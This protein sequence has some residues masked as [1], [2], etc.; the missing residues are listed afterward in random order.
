MTLESIIEI[1]HQRGEAK[2]KRKAK[3]KAKKLGLPKKAQLTK[4]I[5][6][7][8][9]RLIIRKDKDGNKYVL[10]KGK[11][12]SVAEGK[13]IA[14]QLL[15][16]PFAPSAI[17]REALLPAPIAVDV[18]LRPEILE[19]KNKSLPAL[20]DEAR[21]LGIKGQFPNRAALEE[22]VLEKKYEFH[23]DVDVG[24]LEKKFLKEMEK[25]KPVE[26]KKEIKKDPDYIQRQLENLEAKKKMISEL[27]KKGL[28]SKEQ[29]EALKEKEFELKYP[30]L[31]REKEWYEKKKLAQER[32]EA[33][34]KLSEKKEKEWEDVWDV[35]REKP[36]EEKKTRDEE[37]EE[38]VNELA[39]KKEKRWEDIWGKYQEKSKGVYIDNKKNRSLGLVGLPYGSKPKEEKQSKEPGYTLD[40][41]VDLMRKESNQ[42][43][44]EKAYEELKKIQLD[45]EKEME[46]EDQKTYEVKGSGVSKDKG[47]TDTQIDTILKKYPEYLGTIAHNEIP[48]K[49]LP[50]ITPK[51]KGGF[52]IN[53][54]PAS[55]GGQHWQA[56]YFDATP[57]GTHEINFFDSY[58]DPI[59]KTLQKNL[60][61]IA[62]KL[63]A[64]T[65]LKFKENRIRLQGNSSN[66]GWF[67][68]QFL[69]DRFNGKPFADAS[70]Y[71]DSQQGEANISKFKSQHG[72]GYM[73]SGQG[74]ME[75]GLGPAL[76]T[77]YP[78]SV[79]KYIAEQG[80]TPIKSIQVCRTP[81]NSYVQKF[82]NLVTL[83]GLSRAKKDT[84]ISDIFHLYMVI[85]G[86][87]TLERNHVIEMYPGGP[88][89]GSQCIN[90]PL[91]GQDTSAT[92]LTLKILLEKTAAMV[93]PSL[94]VYD[95]R[96]NNCQIFLSQILKANYLD[97]PGILNWIN[98]PVEKI[99]N[100]FPKISG[101]LLKAVTDFAHK[102]DV[103]IKG[104]GR[105]KKITLNP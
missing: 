48:T 52:V 98:Q 12:I 31:K 20:K 81:V 15:F 40:E 60:K 85:N 39:E 55:K 58:G 33:V 2:K 42:A 43:D 5:T 35:L 19:L 18:G 100:A 36:K 30:E 10:H 57:K 46:L 70:G 99:F 74:E 78:P 16:Q 105:G 76:R 56:I 87:I 83:G 8:K 67:C 41:A 11:R 93:G 17:P 95:P 21:D 66:C 77:E 65:Y 47:M 92:P 89:P 49:I 4:K 97:T 62:E 63:D 79:R 102:A 94:Q 32:I 69:I 14:Q 104:R 75:G 51:S 38:A 53:T 25:Q 24:K 88:Q 73:W 80:N 72:F 7:K 68:V 96:T 45:Y 37:R 61:M 71:N 34:N 28:V 6:K 103:L 44:R 22:K 50:K 3:K 64:N 59:D 1:L 27:G 54:D 13:K 91:N 26:R 86:N 84:G 29:K 9:I 82:V 101:S 90:V 23:L